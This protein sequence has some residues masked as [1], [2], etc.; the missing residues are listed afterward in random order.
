MQIL[1]DGKIIILNNIGELL[2]R[3]DSIRIVFYVESC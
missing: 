1:N 2:R 3:K